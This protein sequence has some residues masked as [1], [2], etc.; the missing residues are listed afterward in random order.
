MTA[1]KYAKPWPP[2]F[3]TIYS[4]PE[5]IRPQMIDFA[6]TSP[7]N[8]DLIN[9]YPMAAVRIAT[10]KGTPAERGE[11]LWRLRQGAGLKAIAEALD[12]PV[13]TR[14]V[15]ASAAGKAVSPVLSFAPNCPVLESL[16]RR[17]PIEANA[18]IPW[19]TNLYRI[20]G[21]QDTALRSWLI[22]RAPMTR[23]FLT[24]LI[25]IAAAY[26]FYSNEP[27][28]EASRSIHKPWHSKMAWSEA[29]AE[30]H[31]WLRKAAEESLWRGSDLPKSPPA[32]IPLGSYRITPILTP[33]GL[34]HA[35]DS[36]DN[37]LRTYWLLVIT[38]TAQLFLIEGPRSSRAV[39]DVRAKADGFSIV[40]IKG[41]G[42]KSASRKLVDLAQAWVADGMP[43][44]PARPDRPKSVSEC[45]RHW[46]A[47]WTPFL[48][49]PQ[50][51]GLFPRQ[52]PRFPRIG[53]LHTELAVLERRPARGCGSSRRQNRLR[54]R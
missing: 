19:L 11:A 13:W 30:M 9:S 21:Y 41:V 28:F 43:S 36:M 48:D 33:D 5:A 14:R 4:M 27:T 1:V 37:C 45:T 53:L 46:H 35:A 12:L 38:R 47:L 10:G 54:Q 22:Q 2:V 3:D 7:A 51:A 25:D 42:N 39:F 26:R 40:Q 44:A 6:L 50:H 23:H 17:L 20:L 15:H 24:P 29:M 34:A 32:Q 31:A 18:Q 52:N 8:S 49:A 16:G